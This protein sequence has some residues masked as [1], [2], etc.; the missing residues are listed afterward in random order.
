MLHCHETRKRL[1]IIQK[2][3][4]LTKLLSYCLIERATEDKYVISSSCF[5]EATAV[6]CNISDINLDTLKSAQEDYTRLVLHNKHL[7]LV[8]VTHNHAIEKYV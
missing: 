8:L 7:L 4:V 3:A 5:T 2:K 1:S 6:L